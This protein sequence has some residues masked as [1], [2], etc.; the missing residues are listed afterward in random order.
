M[1]LELSPGDLE[2]RAF[3]GEPDNRPWRGLLSK[4]S[5]GRPL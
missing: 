1:G 5:L 4:A 3:P 2:M